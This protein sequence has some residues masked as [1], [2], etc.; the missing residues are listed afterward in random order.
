L[1]DGIKDAYKEDHFDQKRKDAAREV[2]EQGA[3]RG[4]GGR[5][6]RLKGENIE[7]AVKHRLVGQ[8]QIL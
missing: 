6:G 4:G 7:A 3:C 8:Q 5:M 1:G 2:T